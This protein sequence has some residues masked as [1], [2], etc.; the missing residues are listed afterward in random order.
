MS[1][2][3]H[4]STTYQPK[5]TNPDGSSSVV[6]VC[7]HA[8]QF[9]PAEFDGLGLSPKD[10]DSHAAWDPGALGVARALSHV[11]DAILIEGAVSRLVFDCNR[12]PE[13][14]DGTPSQSEIIRIPGN[15]DLTPEARQ[16]RVDAVYEPFHAAVDVAAT[17]VE[18][19]L[20][21]TLHSFTPVYHGVPRDVEIGI[22][23]DVDLRLADAMLD[24]AAAHTTRIVQRNAPY[25]PRDGVTHT[26]QR[27][28]TLQYRPNVM[29]ELRN[30]LI[31]VEAQQQQAGEM[32]GRWIADAVKRAELPGSV[33]CKV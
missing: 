18:A 4:L 33:K 32:L 6:L 1:Q 3:D 26:L 9:V 8:T 27:H 14:E 23:H 30:D 10:R 28:G 12:L 29:I 13:A 15:E 19:P 31:E 22:L 24:R 16:R 17:E 20:I 5:I 7:E 2:I 21:V 25:G 11:L